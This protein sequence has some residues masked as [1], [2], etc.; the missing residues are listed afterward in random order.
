VSG[1]FAGIVGIYQKY[2]FAAEMRG[3]LEKWGR[4]V[5]GNITEFRRI[6]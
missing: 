6:A 1:S 2:N 4:H 5:E 3:A